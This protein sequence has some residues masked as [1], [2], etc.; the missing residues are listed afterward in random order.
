MMSAET[1]FG[2][3]NCKLVEIDWPCTANEQQM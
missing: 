2:K 3:K 1:R